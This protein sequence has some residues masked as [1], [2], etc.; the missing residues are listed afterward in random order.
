MLFGVLPNENG[1]TDVNI[2]GTYD[3]ELRDL[4]TVI[5]EL[6]TGHIFIDLSGDEANEDRGMD[7]CY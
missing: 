7:K 6:L 4:N 1:G 3:T 2:E 5:Q